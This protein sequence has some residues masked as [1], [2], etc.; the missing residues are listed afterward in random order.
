MKKQNSF[1]QK[2]LLCKIAFNYLLKLNMRIT[3]DLAKL[4]T[5]IRYENQESIYKL[6]LS[7]FYQIIITQN[8]II[9]NFIKK[10]LQLETMLKLCLHFTSSSKQS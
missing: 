8:N 9:D 5:E 6:P 4:F 10:L 7:L 3:Y 1:F 2:Q